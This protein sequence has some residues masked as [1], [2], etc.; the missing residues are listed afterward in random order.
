MEPRRY[1]HPT[2]TL[3]GDITLGDYVSIWPSAVIRGDIASIKIGSW[4]NVQDCCVLHV[5]TGQP[6]LIGNNVT[7]GHGAILHG[8]TIGDN[9][10]IGMGAIILDKA[11]IGANCLIAAGSLVPPAKIIPPGSLV[12][13]QPGR[14]VRQ[15]T[16]EELEKQKNSPKAYWQLALRAM[17]KEQA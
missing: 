1:I 8:C 7:I 14:V 16:A 10:I 17:G 15:L 3:M 12:M 4:T 13:G 2:A 6:L 5:E 9:C 11:Q